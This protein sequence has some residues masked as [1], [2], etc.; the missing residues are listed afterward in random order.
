MLYPLVKVT[1]KVPDVVIGVPEILNP[2]GTVIATD[3]TVPLVE[4]VPAPIAVLNVAA[5]NQLTVLSAFALKNVIAD[6]FVDVNIFP[7]IVVAPNDVLPVAG[8]KPVEPP[9]HFILSEYAVFQLVC[10]DV[11]GIIY[12]DVKLNTLVFFV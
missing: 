12:P 1:A 2:V 4:L 7:P 3:V 6:G 5:S 10:S 11:V 9:S 8:T